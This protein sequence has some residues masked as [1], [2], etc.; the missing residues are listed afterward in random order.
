MVV[1]LEQGNT[2]QQKPHTDVIHGVPGQHLLGQ[3]HSG[4]AIALR[5]IKPSRAPCVCRRKELLST[6]LQAILLV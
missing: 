3:R 1:A 2:T 6:S 5:C 4:F